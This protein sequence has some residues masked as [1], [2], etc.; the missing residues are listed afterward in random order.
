GE[1][2]GEVDALMALADLCLDQDRREEAGEYAG[3]AAVLARNIADPHGEADAA[4]RAGALELRAGRFES[5]VSRF[6]E[7]A[8]QADLAADDYPR[9]MAQTGLG[10]AWLEL[11]RLDDAHAAAA[12]AVGLAR[13]RGYRLLEAEALVVLAA[14]ATAGGRPVEAADAA[15]AAVSIC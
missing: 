7:A 9:I 14:I 6:Q 11:G 13:R 8:H 4:N 2:R 12:V 5:A 1:T 3:R 15:G 10:A